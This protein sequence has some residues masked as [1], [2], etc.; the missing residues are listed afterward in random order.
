[1]QQQWL[2]DSL[3]LQKLTKLTALCLDYGSEA[4]ALQHLGGLTRLQDFRL[5]A[6][7]GWA[8]AGC[9][10]MQE[11]KALTQLKLSLAGYSDLPASVSQLT[12]LQQLHVQMAISTALSKLSALTGLTQLCVR[13]LRTLSPESPPLQLPGL[14]HLEVYDGGDGTVPMSFLASCTQLRVLKLCKINLSPGSLVASTMLQ[15]LE[16]DS[17]GASPADAAA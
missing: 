1:V 6:A 13:A 14:Q 8:A 4:K 15:H 7:D 10:G 3:L 9:P 12:A 2:I 16:V 11:L 5:A 17:C